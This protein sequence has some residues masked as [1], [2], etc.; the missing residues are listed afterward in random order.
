[1]ATLD[2][3]KVD[4][5]IYGKMPA[6]FPER[7]S[8]DVTSLLIG[9]CDGTFGVAK[10]H[11]RVMQAMPSLKNYASRIQSITNGVRRK[12]WQAPEF[13]NYGQLSD[14]EIF[15]LKD[16][17]RAELVE[18]AWRRFHLW[19][20]W[21][22]EA[23]NKKIIL[24]TRRITPYKRL[25]TLLKLLKDPAMRTRFLATDVIMFI[26]G[27]IHQQDNHAQDI[28]FDMLDLMA[29]DKEVEKRVV[30]VDNFN[31]WEAPILFQGCDGTVMM[32]DDT[33]EAS[34]TGFMKAQM[35]GAAVVAT[36]DGAV[37]EFVLFQNNMAD[38]ETL[39]G[40]DA[41]DAKSVNGFKVPYVRHEPTPVGL[42]EALEAFDKTFKDSAQA[43]KLIRAAFDVTPYV[44]VART[45]KETIV[46]YE[47]V[48]KPATAATP[49]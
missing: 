15:K 30:F 23:K 47:Q 19:R 37:P 22:D 28:V 36:N 12:D 44:D 32:A 46:F 17:K 1:L 42:L 45:V 11:K 7:R 40:Q 4:S 18:W 14:E 21:A 10:K 2:L 20:S 41:P 9:V 5:T 24:W 39:A 43:I 34:A 38:D 49:S 13:V 26:G 35:N 6:W 25:D 48:L 8:L 29:K 33:R 27:R 3:V 31:V 16:Q